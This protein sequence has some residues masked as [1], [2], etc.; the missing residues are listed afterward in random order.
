MNTLNEKL[1]FKLKNNL[2]ASYNLTC[3]FKEKYVFWH[4]DLNSEDL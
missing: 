4:I 3:I 2:M 1:K